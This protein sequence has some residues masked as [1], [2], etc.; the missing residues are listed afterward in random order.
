MG[1][2]TSGKW[3]PYSSASVTTGI[4]IPVSQY[5][6]LWL[7][8]AKAVSCLPDNQFQIK[9]LADVCTDLKIDLALATSH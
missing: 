1:L 8:L 9:A 7:S 4:S 6:D 2:T 3:E 5:P